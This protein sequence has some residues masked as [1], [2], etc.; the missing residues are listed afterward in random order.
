MKIRRNKNHRK[1]LRFY[2]IAFGLQDPFRIIVDGTFVTQ[3]LQ[4]KVH[5]K[6]QLPKMLD[7][8]ATPMTTSCVMAELRKLGERAL[9]ASIISKGYYR[10]KCG[11]GKPIAASKCIRQQVGSSNE[12]KFIVATQDAKLLQE[13]RDEVPGLPLLRMDGPVPRIEEPSAVTKEVANKHQA[14]ITRPADWEKRKLPELVEREV[15]AEAMANAPKKKKAQKGTNPLA[16]L[17]GK[18]KT[19][20][21]PHVAT[22][23]LRSARTGE[24]EDAV[25]SKRARSARSR[26]LRRCR[27]SLAASSSAFADAAAAA[28]RAAAKAEGESE[29]DEASA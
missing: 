20:T 28:A 24:D 6:E 25:A 17:K 21:H 26:K 8:R 11:H 5:V 15:K 27:E 9:G 18:K 13:L 19:K 1:I 29:S 16:L 22:Q 14:Q 12:R 10:L 23:N 2:R 3:A 4:H 7:G